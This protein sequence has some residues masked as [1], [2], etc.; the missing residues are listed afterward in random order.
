[1]RLLYFPSEVICVA[2]PGRQ[3]VI[4]VVLQLGQGVAHANAVGVADFGGKIE[5]WVT[6][7]W[8]IHGQCLAGGFGEIHES[9][10]F[11]ES[12]VA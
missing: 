5:G 4:R 2:S 8:D 7:P 1:M 9:D 3:C 6:R 10:Q 11:L 12:G